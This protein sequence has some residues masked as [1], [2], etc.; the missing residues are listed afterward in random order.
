[1]KLE[2]LYDRYG[3]KMY[4]YLALRLGSSA[5]AEDVLQETFC[6][7]ARYSVR[8]T[9]IDNPRAFIFKVLRNEFNRHLKRRIGRKR[10]EGAVSEQQDNTPGNILDRPAG[11]EDAALA[12]TIERALAELPD[13]Q[14]EVIILKVYQGFSFREIAGICRLSTATAAS[15]YRYG[16]QKLR[17]SLEGKV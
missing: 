7:L 11:P 4:Q 1:M 6:R 14:K 10:I 12:K 5:D 2:E 17:S 9:L 15:R 8:W 13:E 3:E 16:M